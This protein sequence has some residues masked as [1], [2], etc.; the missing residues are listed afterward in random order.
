M[1][2]LTPLSGPSV[3]GAAPGPDSEVAPGRV[4]VGVGVP[5]L[6]VCEVRKVVTGVVN[7]ELGRTG[8]A[9]SRVTIFWINAR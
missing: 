1:L 4:L 2:A 3:G 5:R 6:K 7:L 9:V 8:E